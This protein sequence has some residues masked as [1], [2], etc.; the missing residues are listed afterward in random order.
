MT[1]ASPDDPHSV[2]LPGPASPDTEPSPADFAGL[3]IAFAPTLGGRVPVERA[4]LDVVEAQA[5]ALAGPRRARRVGLPG[6]RRFGASI[7]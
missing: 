6:S 5:R 4:V 2:F 3:R 1:G 7:P